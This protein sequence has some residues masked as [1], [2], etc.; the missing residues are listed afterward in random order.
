MTQPTCMNQ[1]ILD[2]YSAQLHEPLCCT[3]LFV[4]MSLL[5]F[6]CVQICPEIAKCSTKYFTLCKVYTDD[7]G[8]KHLNHNL[9]VYAGDNLRAK[10]RGLSTRTSGQTVV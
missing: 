3:R 1:F 6:C 7:G 10:A 2:Y 5:L 4:L 8:I 9:S